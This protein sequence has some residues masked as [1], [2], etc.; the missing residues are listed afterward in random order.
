M[1][2]LQICTQNF[3]EPVRFA[4]PDLPKIKHDTIYFMKVS[5]GFK[6]VFGIVQSFASFLH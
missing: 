5:F 6:N 3:H 2:K 1:S 4:I